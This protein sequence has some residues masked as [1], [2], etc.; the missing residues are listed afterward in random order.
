MEIGVKPGMVLIS[1]TTTRSSGVTKKS[2]R[3]SPAQSSAVNAWHAAAW[4][5]AVTDGSTSAGTSKAQAS[6]GYFASKSYQSCPGRSRISAGTLASGNPSA[7][8]RTPDSISR[9]DTAASTMTLLSCSKATVTAASRSAQSVTLVMPTLDPAR[10]RLTN[11]G[12][13]SDWTSIADQGRPRRN[14]TNEPTS[15]PLARSR[16]LVNS[17]SIPAALANT[18]GPT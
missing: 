10:A 11:T 16:I 14:T 6:S 4:I 13:P 3:A 17:L 5:S 18:P 12:S 7:F 9:P 15:N 2:T 1:L 8:S